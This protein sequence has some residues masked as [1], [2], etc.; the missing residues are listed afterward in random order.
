M[1]LVK[2]GPN[3]TRPVVDFRPVNQRTVPE[4]TP[5][6]VPRDLIDKT[7]GSKFFSHL[8]VKWSFMQVRLSPE[9]IELTSFCVP[10]GQFEFL[11]LPFGVRNGSSV[12]QRA[13]RDI[14]EPLSRKGVIQFVDDLILHTKTIA[15]HIQLIEEVLTLL[16]NNGVVLRL[17]KC[18]FV[19]TE[20]QFLGHE[21]GFR[22][23]RPTEAKTRAITDFPTP[24]SVTAVRS[25]VGL[26][27]FYRQFIPA[28]SVI[29]KLLT[30]LTRKDLKFEWTEEADQ[31]FNN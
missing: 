27:N 30:D 14:I 7:H 6:P 16:A 25:F 1:F 17:E 28:F 9:S 24:T 29:V 12:F 21:V 22:F 10:W 19:M 20:I 31:A 23:L 5:L 11:F 4:H 3:D 8:D 2:K 13:L 26:A 18:S 15:E